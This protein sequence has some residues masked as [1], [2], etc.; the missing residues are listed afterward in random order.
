MKKCLV[1]YS[2]IAFHC[3]EFKRVFRG[4]I[5]YLAFENVDCSFMN[6]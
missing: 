4:L 1:K 6:D 2:K 3:T 5:A